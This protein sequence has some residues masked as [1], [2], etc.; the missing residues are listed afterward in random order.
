MYLMALAVS[1]YKSFYE[2]MG[3]EIVGKGNHFLALAEYE[4][5]IYGW[6]NLRGN[7]NIDKG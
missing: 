5:I 7:S 6:N 4:T 1:P 2:K 3:G